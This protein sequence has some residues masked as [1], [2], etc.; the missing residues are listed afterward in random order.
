[1]ARIETKT[2]TVSATP[3]M[4]ISDPTR[5]TIKLLKLYL[6]GT[7]SNLFPST[8]DRVCD[9]YARRA[10]GRKRGAGKGHNECDTD[11]HQDRGV[12]DIEILKESTRLHLHVD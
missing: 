12:F 6:I 2:A 11:R 4:V 7:N 9:R 8:A 1:M 3:R 10:P 5:R